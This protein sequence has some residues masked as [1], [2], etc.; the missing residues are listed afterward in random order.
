M[1]APAH[2]PQRTSPLAR[3]RASKTSGGVARALLAASSVVCG[4]V[5]GQG[6]QASCAVLILAARWPLSSSCDPHAAVF[7]HLWLDGRG[8]SCGCGPAGQGQGLRRGTG[9]R[10]S[11]SCALPLIALGVPRMYFSWWAPSIYWNCASVHSMG[12]PSFDACV[13]IKIGV[14]RQGTRDSGSPANPHA[15]HPQPW[16]AWGY[17]MAWPEPEDCRSSGFWTEL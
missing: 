2:A 11:V 4:A 8:G 15:T 7:I 14:S 5:A 12:T 13:G 10:R 17:S 3:S 9:A 6:P 16:N 1:T